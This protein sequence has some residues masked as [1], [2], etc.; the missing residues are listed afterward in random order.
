[1]V[2]T[3][4]V[5]EVIIAYIRAGKHNPSTYKAPYFPS[6]LTYSDVAVTGHFS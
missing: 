5:K 6:Y 1:M 2:T 4:K 3:V